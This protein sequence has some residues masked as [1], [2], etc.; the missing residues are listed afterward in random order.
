VADSAIAALD[1]LDVTK[2]HAS[3]IINRLRLDAALY[4]PA[5]A[6]RP[7]Q[8]QRSRKKGERLPALSEVLAATRTQWTSLTVPY[9]YGEHNR[10]LQV[11]SETALCY[12]SGMPVIALRWVLIRDPLEQFKTQALL[13]P[14]V[15][16]M[17]A[18][19][20]DCSVQRWQ[21]KVTFEEARSHLG[22]KTR[23]Q[24]SDKAIARTTPCLLGAVFHIDATGAA[25][26]RNRTAFSRRCLV[27][28]ATGHLMES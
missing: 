21:M 24:W 11:A 6:R 2:R 15:H 13:C 17:P 19:I 10:L 23:R 8:H 4:A 25:A 9:W 27:C 7:M 22:V 5:P 3:I 26:V 18:F 12:H 1:F 20:L 28:Q 16:A 14:D